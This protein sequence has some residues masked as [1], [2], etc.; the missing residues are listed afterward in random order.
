MENVYTVDKQ[1]YDLKVL[2][3]AKI[4]RFLHI[5]TNEDDLILE[6]L[7][8]MAVN[9]AETFLG[10]A[11][12]NKDITLKVHNTFRRV[13]VPLKNVDHKSIKARISLDNEKEKE[14]ECTISGDG[15]FFLLKNIQENQDV[16]I[17]YS[18]LQQYIHPQI[19][20]GIILHVAEMY[21]NP[22]RISASDHILKLYYPY[23]SVR[24]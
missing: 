19:V 6:S 20:R 10:Y 21:D 18:T 2:D 14:V 9:T 13:R 15:N 24:L 3:I 17:S 22:E 16:K 4:K 8:E 23:R 5:S 7:A 11:I 12:S 1:S